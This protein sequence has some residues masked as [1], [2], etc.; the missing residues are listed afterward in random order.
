MLAEF[1]DQINSIIIKSPIVMFTQIFMVMIMLEACVVISLMSQVIN[2]L[3]QQLN[4]VVFL[5]Q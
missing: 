4:F 2:K 1:V 5:V 3:H